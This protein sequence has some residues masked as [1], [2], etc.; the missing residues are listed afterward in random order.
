MQALFI[1]SA[2]KH[3]PS[4]QP[5]ASGCRWTL[6]ATDPVSGAQGHI[7]KNLSEGAT[8]SSVVNKSLKCLLFLFPPLLLQAVSCCF[9]SPRWLGSL[10]CLPA[11]AGGSFFCRGHEQQIAKTSS[12]AAGWAHGAP[13]PW[14]ALCSLM[15]PTLLCAGLGASHR[16]ALQVPSLMHH[17][18]C[19]SASSALGRYHPATW[20]S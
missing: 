7:W 10:G 16:A 11:L 13:A 15:A 3:G 20:A 12:V 1:K 18:S 9:S 2:S 8:V 6:A 17:L 5:R 19:C 4:A 14:V